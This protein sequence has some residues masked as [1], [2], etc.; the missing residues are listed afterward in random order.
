MRRILRRWRLVGTAFAAMAGLCGCGRG[1]AP[2]DS[3]PVYR[4][5]EGPF[6]VWTA[7][8]GELAARRVVNISSQFN[9]PAVLTHLAPEGSKVRAGDVIVRFDSFQAENEL[10]RLEREVAVAEAEGASLEH[11]VLPLELRELEIAL[12]EAKYALGA[13]RQSLA[14][15]LELEQEGLMSAQEVERDRL[16]A[17]HAESKVGQLEERIRLVRAHIHPA[18]RE[19][20]RAKRAAALRQRDLMREQVARCA[21]AAPCD[22]EVVHLPLLF[23]TELRPARVGDTVYKNQEFMSIPEP[24]A[25]VVRLFVPERELARVRPGLA[26]R[27]MPRAWPE[28]DLPGVVESVAAIS[29]PRGASAERFFACSIRVEESPPELKSGLTADVA[30]RSQDVEKAVLL[31]R[32]AVN[33]R[34]GRPYGRVRTERGIEER[35][36]ILGMANDRVFEVRSGLRA[37]E[38]VVP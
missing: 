34:D 27:V 16:Q 2:M 4:V 6:Q 22:G 1:S 36:L 10:A 20:S 23:G 14:D 30:V 28:L 21:V 32:A 25:W 12:A 37:G 29:S 31:P 8:E 9:G 38:Q 35:A 15:S 13:A 24:G 26:A 17:G 33:W 7:Y 11:A 19:E 3:A 18:R 5:E